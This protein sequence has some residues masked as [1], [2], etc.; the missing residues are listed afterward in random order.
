M[1]GGFG[2]EIENPTLR[3]LIGLVGPDVESDAEA[4]AGGGDAGFEFLAKG[5]GPSF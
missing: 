2:N 4:G 5:H 3:G 1:G